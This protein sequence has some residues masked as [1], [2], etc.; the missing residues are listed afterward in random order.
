MITYVNI[1]EA[2][3]EVQEKV[4]L[5]RNSPR[6]KSAMTGGADISREQHLRWLQS[7]AGPNSLNAVRVA[8]ADG[9]PFGFVNLKSLDKSAGTTDWGLYIG[10]DAFLGRGLGKRLTYDV[11]DWGFSVSG[12]DKMYSVVRSDNLRALHTYLQMGICL[13]G[14]LKNHLRSP[15][16]ESVGL[17]LIALFR[18]EWLA[19]KERNAAWGKIG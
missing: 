13:E 9:V 7:L 6:V 2:V 16:G 19:S 11:H 14:Y 8:F 15:S 3:P 12:I 5:W 17:Y 1:L 4:R 10:E 18:T